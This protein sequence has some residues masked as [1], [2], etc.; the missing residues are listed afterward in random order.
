[1]VRYKRHGLEIKRWARFLK[2]AREK[3][4]DRPNL[5]IVAANNHYASF[6]PGTA[7]TFKKM[8]GLLEVTWNGKVSWIEDTLHAKE[9]QTSLSDFRNKALVV[10]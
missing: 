2:R 5:S 1:L 6:G 4:R 10:H 3:Q 9:T 8:L 7:N